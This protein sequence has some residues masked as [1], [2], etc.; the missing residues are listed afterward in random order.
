MRYM[1]N[2]EKK[3]K[4][5][6]GK[7]IV[8]VVI[9]VL[10][11]ACVNYVLYNIALN[12]NFTTTYYEVKSEKLT[13]SFR[14]V[15]ISDLHDTEY[16][17]NN[18]DLIQAVKEAKP[19]VIFC[20][21]DMVSKTETDFTQIKHVLTELGKIAP[22]YYGFGNHEFSLKLKSAFTDL[23]E[24]KQ[25]ENVH[26]IEYGAEEADINGNHIKIGA[27]CISQDSW[28]RH[29]ERWFSLFDDP[30]SF[31]VLMSHYPW[32]I[33]DNKPDTTIDLVLSGHTHGGQVHLWDDVG[34]VCPERGFFIPMTSGIH[35][36]NGTTQEIVSR[37]IGDHTFIPRIN[38]QPELIVIDFRA[39][40]IVQ[41]GR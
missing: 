12:Q 24:I 15:L 17:E 16:G 22:V 1:K 7:V 28:S 13:S 37:G 10:I 11:F 31:F 9:A 25:I 5:G 40:K 20:A 27:F 32:T 2:L 23:D 41:V 3:S 35:T 8:R 6:I 36:I 14:G 33:P 30:R 39:Q 21:G 38:N 4:R 34:L 29:G 18:A 19:D 26:V